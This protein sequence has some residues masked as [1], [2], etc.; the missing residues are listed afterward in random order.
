MKTLKQK[1]QRKDYEKKRNLNRL[2]K[3]KSSR[4]AYSYPGKHHG[5]PFREESIKEIQRRLKK[6]AKKKLEKK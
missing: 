4:L 1:K 2:T 3:T 6:E 5:L